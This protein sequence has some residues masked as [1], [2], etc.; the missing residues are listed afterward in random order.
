M[1]T[2][3]NTT[4]TKSFEGQLGDIGFN[5]IATNQAQEN[6]PFGRGLVNGGEEIAVIPS[7]TGS[8]VFE[9]VSLHSYEVEL[10]S[11]NVRQYVDGDAI[12][13]L[14]RGRVWVKSE[15][16][17]AIGDPV[18]LRHTAN[19]AT[20]LPGMFTDNADNGKCYLL[21]GA[22]WLTSCGAGEL[23]LLE[24]SDYVTLS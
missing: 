17:I 10:D 5:D 20:K 2:S 4:T 14:K 3:I 13:T 24:V 19:G 6:V 21:T 16:A 9:G 15:A 1:Q 7:S 12:N 22:R 18:Y 23:A 11:N 8:T